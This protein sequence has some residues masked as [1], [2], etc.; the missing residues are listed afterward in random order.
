M[1]NEL[2]PQQVSLL[3]WLGEEEFFRY[4][5]CYGSTLDS[6]IARGLAQVHDPASK[7]DNATAK[8]PRHD[9]PRRLADAGRP[10]EARLTP[11]GRGAESISEPFGYIM[12]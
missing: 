5:E 10:D 9:V 7:T 11:P 1:T 6:L 12:H 4:S 8:R 2:T 3:A